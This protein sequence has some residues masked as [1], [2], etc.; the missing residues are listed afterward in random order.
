MAFLQQV[1]NFNKTL[2][3][4]HSFQFG[5]M[6]SLQKKVW[7]FTLNVNRNIHQVEAAQGWRRIVHVVSQSATVIS[8]T[9]KD[10]K[11]RT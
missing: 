6:F 7:Y 3:E 9:E 8:R 2:R 1:L 10:I 11:I 4:K 5:K